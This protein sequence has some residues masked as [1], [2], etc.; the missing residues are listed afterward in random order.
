MPGTEKKKAQDR[1]RMQKKR[2]MDAETISAQ[3]VVIEGL[4]EAVRSIALMDEVD[5]ALDPIWAIRIAG[6]AWR[7]A[8]T[9]IYGLPSPPKPS[10]QTTTEER[11]DK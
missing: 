5:A 10:T 6:A 2:R 11:N 1:E 7:E 3:A 9:H 4:I 8:R